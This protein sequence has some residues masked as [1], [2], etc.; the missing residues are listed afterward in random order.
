MKKLEKFVKIINDAMCQAAA[1]AYSIHVPAVQ[2]FDDIPDPDKEPILLDM[3]Y[4]RKGIKLEDYFET[5]KA[6]LK[7]ST[8]QKNPN[9]AEWYD[10][11]KGYLFWMPDVK[12]WSCRDDILSDEYPK[13]WYEKLG[14]DNSVVFDEM[15]TGL[16]D[17]V[18]CIIRAQLEN[19]K[20]VMPVLGY[21]EF[22]L[23]QLIRKVKG[24][25]KDG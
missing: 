24:E 5:E 16:E 19:K 17:A 1:S 9:D 6:Y 2:N 23:K 10:T 12:S 22:K 20:E 13:F 15:L 8:K 3:H 21:Y 18:K 14:D 4:I 11:D 25:L 7:H